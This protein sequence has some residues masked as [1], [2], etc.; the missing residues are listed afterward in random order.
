MLSS[1]SLAILGFITLMV[2]V[3]AA[4]QLTPGAA[5]ANTP[6]VA[7]DVLLLGAPVEAHPAAVLAPSGADVPRPAVRA[8]A[9]TVWELAD[10]YSARYGLDDRKVLRAIILAESDGNPQVV[11][12]TGREWS[13]GLLQANRLGGRGEGLSE[14]ELLDPERNLALGMPEIAAAY[15]QAVADGYRGSPLAVRVAQLA[16]RPD[17]DTL[18]RFAAAYDTL[19]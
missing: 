13:V 12:R 3:G 10:R 2:Y 9:E 1:R 18:Y 19:E 8:A 7:Q 15:R 11:K 14:A 5:A 16:Q 6:P 4:R 17:P